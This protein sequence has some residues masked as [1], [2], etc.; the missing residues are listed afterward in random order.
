MLL[1]DF[2]WIN[3]KY[4]K[5]DVD[6]NVIAVA[7]VGDASERDTNEIRGWIFGWI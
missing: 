2:K 6:I 7:K 5:Y 1:K 3:R 4:N